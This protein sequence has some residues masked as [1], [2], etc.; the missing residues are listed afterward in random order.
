MLKKFGLILLAIMLVFGLIM[1]SCNGDGDDDDKD[2]NKGKDNGETEFC[3]L[4]ELAMPHVCYC[5]LCDIV[6]SAHTAL[7]CF[8]IECEK[9]WEGDD[10]CECEYFFRLLT[11]VQDGTGGA[12]EVSD[13][14]KLEGKGYIVGREFT[15]I[16]NAKFGSFVRVSINN[17]DNVS[18]GAG[19]IGYGPMHDETP[20][21]DFAANTAATFDALVPVENLYRLSGFENASAIYLNIW[22]GATIEKAMFLIPKTDLGPQTPQARD[23]VITSI[24]QQYLDEELIE[25]TVAP[26]F[27]M[28]QGT[29]TIW[30]TGTGSTDYPKSETMPEIVGD[31]AVTF[32]VAQA[33]GFNAVTG[34]VAGNL[35]LMATEPTGLFIPITF[36]ANNAT[37]ILWSPTA[38]QF[39]EIENVT[40]LVLGGT[41]SNH[42]AGHG[43]GGLQSAFNGGGMGWTQTDLISSGWVSINHS[44]QD[45]FI[46]F[47]KLDG[48]TGYSS[49][50][51]STTGRQFLLQGQ[52]MNINTP[53][54]SVWNIQESYIANDAYLTSLGYLPILSTNSATIAHGF[55]VVEPID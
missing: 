30:Y 31:F 20:R 53:G 26:R 3:E 17:P 4:C 5:P 34:L 10:K 11:I 32:D 7:D 22:S 52:N 19:A 38:D 46:M 1:V 6:N 18:W 43:M 24:N 35:R 29:I 48:L 16:K 27:R 12:P 50:L 49:F 2:K 39:D 42:A 21:V 41:N 44:P 25:F 45:K 23:F 37:Q 51:T 33:T 55:I 28:S 40:Y 8:C 13:P 15:N 36:T 47:I 9:D 54:T 14:E